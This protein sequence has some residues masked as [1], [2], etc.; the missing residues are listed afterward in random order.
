MLF[1]SEI[2]HRLETEIAFAQPSWQDSSKGA[3]E[4]KKTSPG[5]EDD[6]SSM[7]LSATQQAKLIA[8]IVEAYSRRLAAC[9]VSNPSFRDDCSADF[10]RVVKSYN[11]YQFAISSVR[12][13]CR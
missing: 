7:C 12:N 3:P 1:F 5:F 11:E 2:V 4:Q 8:S 6:Q 9:A 10:T 13:Y